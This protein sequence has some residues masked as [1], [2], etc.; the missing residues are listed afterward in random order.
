MIATIALFATSLAFA[1]VGD[2]NE[3]GTVAL[4]D[5]QAVIMSAVGLGMAF[6][7]GSTT[8]VAGNTNGSDAIDPGDAV[9]ILLL[10]SGEIDA[11]AGAGSNWNELTWEVGTWG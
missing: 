10:L 1:A 11:F 8:F 7:P 4:D 5:A 2:F 3:D 9:L 6:P